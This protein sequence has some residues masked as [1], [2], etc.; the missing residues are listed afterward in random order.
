MR[1]F[2]AAI[3]KLHGIRD[4]EH[5]DGLGFEPY[6]YTACHLLW[7]RHNSTAYSESVPEALRLQPQSGRP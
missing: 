4:G 1:C 7:A 5:I 3:A 6:A 2:H